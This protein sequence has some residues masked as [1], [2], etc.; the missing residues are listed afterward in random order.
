MRAI[1]VGTRHPHSRSYQQS[2][3]NMPD[4]EVIA[5]CEPDDDASGPTTELL[6]GKPVYKHLSEA[7][8]L[9]DWELAFVFLPNNQAP[10]VVLEL[11]RAGKHVFCDKPGGSSG[12][13]WEPIVAEANR[14]GVH[15]AM[16]YTW[17]LNPIATQI[18]ELV[19]DGELG[20]ILSVQAR[21][22][23]A[24]VG[25][26]GPQHYLFDPQVSGGGILNWLGCHWI[27]LCRYLVGDEIREVSALAGCIGDT[28]VKVEDTL[29]LNA[30]L[31]GGAYFALQTGYVLPSGNDLFW[32]LQGTKGWVHWYPG[33]S[34][35]EI[36]RRKHGGLS[37]EERRVE[38]PKIPGYGADGRDTL[39]AWLRAIR[40]EAEPVCT[41]ED[42]CRALQVMDAAY[43]S[44]R[45]GRIIS[46][47][48]V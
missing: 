26:R 47:D 10:K 12:S 37:T 32:G 34:K 43:E 9:P 46:V 42:I 25:A 35:F 39:E 6:E 28:E 30:R 31:S 3:A 20:R 22:L 4:I 29:M 48:T 45:V 36:V 14:Y 1:W 7:L 15:C 21:L 24:D 5:L 17:R 2:V 8:A 40:N 18:R 38:S 11:V 23:T 27:D 41:A 16:G 13:D 19:A 33:E 44:A